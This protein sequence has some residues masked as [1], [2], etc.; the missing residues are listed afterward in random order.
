MAPE[1]LLA[2]WGSLKQVIAQRIKQQQR[3]Q[4]GS[5]RAAEQPVAAARA[6][7]DTATA[8]LHASPSPFPAAELQ[9]VAAARRHYDAVSRPP[10]SVAAALAAATWHHANEQPGTHLTPPAPPPSPALGLLAVA[11]SATLPR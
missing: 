3:L 5:H 11:C 4:A 9:A 10:A 6:A 7:L 1:Q 8:A 2:H